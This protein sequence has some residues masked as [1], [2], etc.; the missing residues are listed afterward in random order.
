M[1]FDLIGAAPSIVNALRR[2]IVAEVPTM[3]IETVFVVNNTSIIPDEVLS[4]RLGLIPIYADPRKFEFPSSES[5]DANTVVFELHEKCTPIKGAT[6][7]ASPRENMR[8]PLVHAGIRCGSLILS[9]L[10]FS[11]SLKWVPQGSQEETFSEGPLRPCHDDILVAK[12]RPGQELDLE[13]HCVKGLGKDH[14]KWS[15]V[16]TAPQIY[17]LPDYL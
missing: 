7:D 14:A 9:K 1:E 4:H 6:R 8:N 16:C 10:V 12:L 13:L 11:G 15:P 2:T 17:Q 3:A 5:T